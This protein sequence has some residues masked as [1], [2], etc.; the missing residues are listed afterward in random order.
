MVRIAIIIGTTRPGRKAETVARWVHGIAAERDDATFEL[1]DIAEFALPH[2]DEPAPAL[3]GRYAQ[4]HTRQWARR[5]ESFDGFVFV[6]PEYNQSMPGVLKTAIDFLYAEWNG[7]AAAFVGYGV[8]GA[9]RA[10]AHL[11]SV[12]GALKIADIAGSVALSLHDDFEGF[13][14]FRPRPHQ[15][16]RALAM[17]DE[18]VAW[19]R[20]LRALREPPERA[21]VGA[22]A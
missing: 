6:T 11:R 14:E 3:A 18:L 4:A 1:V 10:V 20:A 8:D 5:I 15:R 19:S 12:M 16:E 2:L 22:V 13:S 7:K 9:A 17:L 21:S